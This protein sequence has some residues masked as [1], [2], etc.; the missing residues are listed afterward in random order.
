MMTNEE[1]M[2]MVQGF[3]DVVASF[4]PVRE[5]VAGYRAALINEHGFSTEAA[6]AMAVQ[7]HGNLIVM[8]TKA[9]S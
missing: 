8:I 2:E 9:T 3:A 7:F 5:A 1:I 6:E 4:M